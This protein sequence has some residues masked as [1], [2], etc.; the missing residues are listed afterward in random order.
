MVSHAV[1]SSPT[2]KFMTSFSFARNLSKVELRYFC[3]AY[4]LLHLWVKR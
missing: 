4:F 3:L 2:T 1:F